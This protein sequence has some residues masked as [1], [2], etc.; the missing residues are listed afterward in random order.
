[1]SDGR[2]RASIVIR[3]AVQGVGFRPFVFRLATSLG[4]AG[5]VKNSSSGVLIEAEGEEARIGELLL[6][7]ERE[8]P[9]LAFIQSLESRLLDP[10][11][12]LA[13]FAILPSDETGEK[14][15]F[16]LPDVATC[17]DCLSE[18][19]DPSD[20]RHL[21]PFT[22]C[23]NCGPRFTIIEALPYDRSRTT[24]RRF[25]M[26]APCR[27]EYENPRDRRFHAEPVA[28]PACGPRLAL[29]DPRGAVLSSEH[30]ALLAAAAS[31]RGGLVVALKGLGGFHLVVDARNEEAVRRLR[32]R[33]RREEK[34][35]ALMV[36]TIESA[37]EACAVSDLEERLL[38]S[39]E[40]P[41]VLLRRKETG[42]AAPSVAPR[43]PYLGLM[44]PYT[45]LHHLLLHV[46]GFP[47]VA[48][49][50]NLSDEPICTDEREALARLGGIADLFLVHD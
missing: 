49:S 31:I 14:S 39:P 4:L 48:T 8:K 46:L 35:L 29:W 1:M 16:V 21:Y 37:R 33:K 23:T 34:P 25:P 45:P 47:V 26:C 6:R 3:G 38:R 20:R 28:C 24:M 22:N 50:G 40:S 15:A 32:E 12:L 41:I 11:G 10:A 30:E 7:L 18:V 27:E 13:P 2:V 9:P 5:S 42:E 17:P 36:P 44:L 19:F 43:N